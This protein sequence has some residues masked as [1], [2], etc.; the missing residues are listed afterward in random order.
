MKS[1]YHKRKI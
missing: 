1:C